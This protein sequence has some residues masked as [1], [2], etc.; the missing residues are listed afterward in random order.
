MA[1]AI[2][3]HSKPKVKAAPAEDRNGVAIPQDYMSSVR[4]NI[5]EAQDFQAPVEAGE[6]DADGVPVNAKSKSRTPNGW[7]YTL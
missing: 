2:P 1:D 5:G 6:L 4:D 3:V 7:A